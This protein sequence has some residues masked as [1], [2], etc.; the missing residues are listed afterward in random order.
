MQY[1]LTDEQRGTM[2]G[3]DSGHTGRK[4]IFF[5]LDGTLTDSGTGIINSVLYALDKMA[6]EEP[7][8]EELSRFI[9][10]PLHHTFNTRYGLSNADTNR[11]VGFY[12]EYFNEK[13]WAENQVY[14][15]ISAMLEQLGKKHRLFVVTSKPEVFAR[16]ILTHFNLALF[17]E[18]ITGSGLDNTM[19]D[20]IELIRYTLGA[21]Q[22]DPKAT[23]MVGDRKYDIIGAR[24]NNVR[25]A[26]VLYGYGTEAEL[27]EHGADRLLRTV[28]DLAR[29]LLNE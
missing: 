8:P 6:I 9:G 12:R 23:I 14:S 15:G 16:R 18:Q 19:T 2:A 20:K 21:Y 28:E 13:G 3:P 27:L 17:F 26:G 24:S 5:D 11:A 22:L 1:I 10:P 25:G 4:N 29:F 7:H